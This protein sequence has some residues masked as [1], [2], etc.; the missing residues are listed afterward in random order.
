MYGGMEVLGTGPGSDF[1]SLR[2]WV[3]PR[4]PMG[5]SISSSCTSAALKLSSLPGD[6]EGSNK[7]KHKTTTA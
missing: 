4:L 1:G 6:D 7:I 5:A 2:S 3:L